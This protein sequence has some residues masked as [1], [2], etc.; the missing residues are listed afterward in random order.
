MDKLE[1]TTLKILNNSNRAYK[2][3]NSST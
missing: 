2:I 1:L 3:N